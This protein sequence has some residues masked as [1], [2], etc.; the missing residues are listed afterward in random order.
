MNS[1]DY[2]FL[3]IA[4]FYFWRGWAK[5]LLRSLLEPAAFILCVVY[6]YFYYQRTQNFMISAGIGILGPIVLNLFF[7]LLFAVLNKALKQDDKK[8]HPLQ[9]MNRFFGGLFS[10]SWV[11]FFMGLTVVLFTMIPV[12]ISVLEGL[13]KSVMA[14][15]SMEGIKFL[16]GDRFSFLQ[17]E[18]QPV[19]L[20]N[21]QNY[22]DALQKTPEYKELIKD[23]RVKAVFTDPETMERIQNKDFVGLFND[24]KIQQLMQDP[25]LIQKFF[26]LNQ[27][28]LELNGS[29]G[30][31]SQ[32]ADD[33][34]KNH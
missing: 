28:L 23:D 22:A 32:N 10:L 9:M 26:K 17:K 21:G 3:G 4:V 12:R 24:P 18:T 16:A 11:V 8:E 7:M 30:E 14:S 25:E 34:Y 1:V 6:A 13:R 19:D 15:K 31:R 5:G 20:A 33:I 2:I 27:V 29:Q